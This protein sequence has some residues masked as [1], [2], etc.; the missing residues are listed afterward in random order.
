MIEAHH[1]SKRFGQTKALQDVSFSLPKG[2]IL[3]IMGANGAGKSTLFDILATLDTRF[4]GELHMMGLDVRSGQRAI[5]QN[6]GYLPGRFSLYADL[7]VQENLD[8]FASVYARSV[9]HIYG[10]PI[11][12][13]LRPFANRPAGLLSGGMKQKLSLC[14]ALV[15]QPGLL[16]LDEPTTGIDPRSRHELWQALQS[17]QASGTTIIASTH[18]LDELL[19]TNHILFLHNGLQL[20]FDTPAGLLAGFTKQ[21]A[22]VSGYPAFQLN[23][24]LQLMP[25]SESC[26]LFGDSVRMV[27]GSQFSRHLLVDYCARKGFEKAEISWVSPSMEDVFLDKIVWNASSSVVC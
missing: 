8:F 26:Y 13:G 21:L 5:R 16:F 19:Y 15:H 9:T 23:Q 24:V 18:Y 7:T 3:A 11:W 25:D 1:I 22:S 14:C 2:E 17:L 27:F 4:E 12:E 20:A 6:S 10:H